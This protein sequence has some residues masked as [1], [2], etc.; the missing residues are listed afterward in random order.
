MTHHDLLIIGAGSGNTILQSDYSGMDVAIVEP[1]AFGGT[2]LNRGCIPS[3][4]FVHAADVAL[5][6]RR[7]EALG[8]HT[9][10]ESADWPS[11]R[12]RVLAKIDPNAANGRDYRHGLEN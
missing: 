6:A 2:C 9:T 11:I 1:V 8:V 7:G 12:Y 4:M 3:K 5:S 10:F